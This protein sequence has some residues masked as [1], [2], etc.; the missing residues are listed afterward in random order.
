[1]TDIAI[2][3]TPDGAHGDWSVSDGVL[4]TGSGLTTA[5]L[6]SLFTDR[7]VSAEEVPAGEDRRGWW[8]D[9]YRA[10]PLGSRLWTLSRRAKSN[11]TLLLAE[12]KDMCLEAL[13]WMLEDGVAA[14]VQ[15]QTYWITGDAMGIIVT[16]REPSGATQQAQ[17][18]WAWKGV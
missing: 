15:V 12:A 14:S 5:V 7:V 4:E 1:M 13:N 18:A 17:Y 2:T 16:I 11:A 3:W 9:T 8:G 10:E 6:V